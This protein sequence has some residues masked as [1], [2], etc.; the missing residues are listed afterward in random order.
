MENPKPKLQNPKQI[1]ISKP[2]SVDVMF[3]VIGVLG[4]IGILD[5]GNPALYA[6]YQI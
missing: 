4:F 3:F 6:L 5:C 1:P 2:Q